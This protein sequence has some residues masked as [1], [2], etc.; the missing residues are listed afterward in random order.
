MIICDL[1]IRIPVDLKTLLQERA[2]GN[3][4]TMNGEVLAL[5]KAVLKGK[6]KTNA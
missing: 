1:K 3:D 4:R 2:A 5:L 6:V